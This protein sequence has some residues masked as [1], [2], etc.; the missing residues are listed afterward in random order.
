[1]LYDLTDMVDV[2]RVRPLTYARFFTVL[3]ND[4]Q[5]DHGHLVD[6]RSLLFYFHC[7]C[8]HDKEPDSHQ[9]LK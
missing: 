1:M 8:P 5:D 2:S 9:T 6:L 4:M 3:C 7:F